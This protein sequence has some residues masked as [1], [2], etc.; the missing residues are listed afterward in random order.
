[1]KTITARQL[2]HRLV[3][4][5]ALAVLTVGCGTH[6]AEPGPDAGAASKATAAA[7]GTPV[8]FRCPGEHSAPT[9]SPTATTSEPATPPT[10]HYAE[11]HG[12]L[13]PFPLHG[14]S[15]CDGLAA[16]QRI[17]KALEPLHGRGD[18]D[19]AGTQKALVHLGY[20]SDTVRAFQAGP[21][22]V[23]FLI[24]AH[25]MCLEGELNRAGVQADA[26]GGYPDG[27]GCE[28]PSGGH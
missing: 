6:R 11:N 21:T 1:M 9:P 19:P 3:P 14:Q 28:P 16:V 20:S 26:F 23:G 7:S 25:S 2:R 24:D 18:F 5:A 10:D 27:T 22:G 13:V 12:F 17:R 4:L 15:R 8:D